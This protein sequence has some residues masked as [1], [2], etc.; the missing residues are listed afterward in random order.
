LDAVVMAAG[1]GMRLRPVT[2]RYAKPVLPVDGRPVIAT[3]LR[4]LAGAGVA[5]AFVV[6]GH[7]RDQIEALLGDGRAFGLELAYVEQPQR[8]GSTDTVA[9]ALRAGAEPTL[10]VTAADTVYTRGDLDRFC[11][12]AV[13][14]DGAIAVR[15]DPPPSPPHRHAV[16]IE[17]GLVRR[18]PDDDPANPLA[19]AP[20]WLLGEAV[21]RHVDPPPDGPPHELA[22]V[23]QAAIRAGARVAGVEIGK[24]R[25]LTRPVD[26]VEQNFAYL[27]AL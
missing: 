7:L 11:A 13:G 19:G 3:L 6:V 1:E 9:R 26:L 5:R 22:N 23:F 12:A 27:R 8:L 25:D 2:E 24:T 17:D 18:V 10:L 20:L 15:R 14:H 21:V 16:R 4:E